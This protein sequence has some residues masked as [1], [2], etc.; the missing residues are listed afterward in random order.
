[1]KYSLCFSIHLTNEETNDWF[2][3]LI[4]F[5]ILP[6]LISI[7][8]I[9]LYSRI[10][11]T[12]RKNSMIFSKLRNNQFML[13]LWKV[14]LIILSN[15]VTWLPIA[16]IGVLAI[17]KKSFLTHD[18]YDWIFIAILPLNSIFNIYIHGRFNTKI[19]TAKKL[20]HKNGIAKETTLN[21]VMRE[22]EHNLMGIV[23][24]YSFRSVYVKVFS[25]F[26]ICTFFANVLSLGKEK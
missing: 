11:I 14:S 22:S 6:I 5:S 21:C 12:I 15:L 18:T 25:K 19:S 4:N 10:L 26:N 9:F 3:H 23:I 17:M 1:M 20:K 8:I 2:I 16:F 7:I 24:F 13:L